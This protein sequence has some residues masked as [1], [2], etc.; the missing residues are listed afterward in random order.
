MSDR[1]LDNNFMAVWWGLYVYSI[2]N[3]LWKHSESKVNSLLPNGCFASCWISSQSPKY[4]SCAK[5]K[6]VNI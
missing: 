6:P 4:L 2:A 3:R 5:P 1:V